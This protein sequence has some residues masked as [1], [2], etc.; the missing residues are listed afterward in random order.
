M[1]LNNLVRISDSDKYSPTE[2]VKALEKAKRLGYTMKKEDNKISFILGRIRMN[3]NLTSGEYEVSSPKGEMKGD[4]DVGGK[5]F[6]SSILSVL[7]RLLYD[8]EIKDSIDADLMLSVVEA[9]LKHNGLDNS[10]KAQ[11]SGNKVHIKDLSGITKATI[12]EEGDEVKTQYAAGVDNA[13]KQAIEDIKN[14]GPDVVKDK[15]GKIKEAFKDISP[16]IVGAFKNIVKSI[17]KDVGKDL[18]ESAV[19]IAGP[20][21]AIANEI[22]KAGKAGFSK[23]SDSF[24]DVRVCDALTSADLKN[25]I[26]A[27]GL[28]PSGKSV[29]EM[30]KVIAMAL[31]AQNHPGEEFPDQFDPMLAKDSTK[32]TKDWIN[33]NFKDTDWIL[34]EKI[35]GMRSI[36]SIDGSKVRMTSRSKS[37][38]DFMFTPH[39]DSVLGFQNIKNP[40]KGKTVLDGELFSKRTKIDTGRTVSESPLQAVVALVHMNPKESLEVQEKYNGP[41][42][43]KCFDILFF[44]GKNVQDLPYEERDKLAGTAIEMLRHDNPDLPI[45]KVPSV[46]SYKSAYEI[47]QKFIEE[48]KEGCFEGHSRVLMSDGSLKRIDSIKEGEYVLSWSRENGIESKRVVN[49]FDNGLKSSDEWCTMYHGVKPKARG[50]K[51]SYLSYQKFLITKNHKIFDNGYKPVVEASS[52]FEYDYEMDDYRKQAVLGWILSDGFKSKQG[53]CTIMQKVGDYLEFTKTMFSSFCKSVNKVTISGK[54][55]LIGV[56]HLLKRHTSWTDKY[57][58]GEKQNYVKVCE[59]ANEIAIAYALMGDGSCYGRNKTSIAF[60]FESFDDASIEAFRGLLRRYGIESSKEIDKRVVN[61][62]GYEIKVSGEDKKRLVKLIDRYVHPCMKYKLGV[63]HTDEY[64]YPSQVKYGLVE[65]RIEISPSTNSKYNK[66]Q[67]RAWDLEVEDNHNYFVEGVLVHNCMMKKKS[68]KYK[69]G[70]RSSEMQKLKGFVTV[71]GFITGAVKSSESKGYKDLIGGFKISAYVDG[72]QQEI[73]AVS[74]IPLSV[75]EEATVMKDGKPVLNPDYLNRCVELVGQEFGKNHRLGSARINEWRPDKDPLDCKLTKEDVS[76][77]NWEKNDVKDSKVQDSNVEDSS[78]DVDNLVADVMTRWKEAGYEDDITTNSNYPI[79]KFNLPPMKNVVTVD[80][81]NQMVVGSDKVAKSEAADKLY[82]I[83]KEAYDVVM[84]VNNVNQDDYEPSIQM[85]D[86]LEGNDLIEIIESEWNFL[87]ELPKLKFEQDAESLKFGIKKQDRWI[88]RFDKK[89]TKVESLNGLKSVLSHKLFDVVYNLIQREKI[90]DS[91]QDNALEFIEWLQNIGEL[92]GDFDINNDVIL[93]K[94]S[95]NYDNILEKIK[96]LDLISYETESGD[97]VVKMPVFETVSPIYSEHVYDADDYS[98]NKI[99]A[100]KYEVLKDGKPTYELEKKGSKW[101]C[102]CTG[103]KYRGKCKHVGMLDESLPKRHPREELDKL[104]PEIKEMFKDYPTW[105]IVGSYR[106]GVKD[107]K[108]IDILVETDKSSFKDIEKILQED[109]EYKRT[110]AGPDII[111]GT[112]H[113]YD[114]DVSRVEP[115]EWGSYLLYRTGSADFNIKLRG[116]LKAKGMKLNE[117]GIF[118]KEGNLLANK[119]EKDMFDAMELPYIKPEEREKGKFEK[120]FKKS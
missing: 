83:V 4:I 47:F 20:I 70:N 32:A 102:T 27:L 21:G 73:A 65:R 91:I 108:D 88:G 34:Q 69:Q 120:Y 114:F 104:V 110:M 84:Q 24:F 61:G 39:Q 56:L 78:V 89:T 29:D 67:I 97:I 15:D 8:N 72:K 96:E 64:I 81:E 99:N 12:W 5:S 11:K 43:Y 117:H 92:N 17:S 85:S 3:L 53:N 74:N 28:D 71:D 48:G 82:E 75:R 80:F 40:F 87:G 101:T 31:W 63:G 26:K 60:S 68:M 37:V 105:E 14:L 77:K 115:G 107:W 103:F 98:L 76:P 118:D 22:Y 57:H 93:S 9:Q 7:K 86:S 36:L 106:R 52:C 45:Q 58:D 44:D 79:L 94:D 10:Y 23:K 50:G 109:L 41:L 2:I 100:T 35:N 33:E 42:V 116:W 111:R 1:D 66:K 51:G 19:A 59:D 54:G 38:T 112:Y 25:K 95:K 49:V 55:S 113:G 30:E 18:G 16:K 119:T 46:T 62:A 13:L 90:K 6:V